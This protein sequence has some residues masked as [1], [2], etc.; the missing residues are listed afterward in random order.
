MGEE[1]E[2]PEDKSRP[3]EAEL[4]EFR[5]FERRRVGLAARTMH[6]INRHSPMAARFDGLLC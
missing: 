4:Q 5:A 1:P 6:R 2:R 3:A